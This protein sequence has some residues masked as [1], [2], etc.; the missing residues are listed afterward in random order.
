MINARNLQTQTDAVIYF[1][2]R[3]DIE[4]VAEILD[5][6]LTY[7]DMPKH[8]FIR[9]LG[10]ALNEFRESGDELLKYYKG[11][12][13]AESCNYNKQGFS[14]VGKRSGKYMDLIIEAKDGKVL[15]IY[16]CHCFKIFDLPFKK[17][18]QVLIDK[19]LFEE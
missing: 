9:K 13:T 18:Q 1:I 2:Q 16:E 8:I 17:R 3:L 11:C 19:K 7:Q 6:D 15:D 10:N 4:M 14:F 12:C 5:N